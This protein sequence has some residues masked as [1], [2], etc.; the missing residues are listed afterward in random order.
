MLA[1]AQKMRGLRLVQHDRVH[2]G[3]FEAQSLQDVGELD[4]DAEVVRVE[5]Q[6][7]VM[8]PQAGVFAHVHRQRRDV[9][10]D[11]QLPVLVV[12]GIGLESDRGR[13]GRLFHGAVYY[14]F[15]R[16]FKLVIAFT[17]PGTDRVPSLVPGTIYVTTACCE[18]SAN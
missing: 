6:L 15:K 9:A 4:V 5:F 18:R 1:P 13:S 2:F 12:S 3:M 10:V 7:V 17:V 16:S 11:G 8:G 14:G